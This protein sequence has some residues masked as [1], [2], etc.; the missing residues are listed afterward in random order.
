MPNITCANI[1]AD[2]II[3]SGNVSLGRHAIK[4]PFYYKEEENGSSATVAS[5]GGIRSASI[6]MDLSLSNPI[7]GKSDTVQPLSLST[8]L[9]LKY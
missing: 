9:I 7:Y 2:A 5:S 4:T 8:K 6:G 3:K 1:G